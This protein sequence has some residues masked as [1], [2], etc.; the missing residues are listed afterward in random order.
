M[1]A[2]RRERAWAVGMAALVAVLLVLVGWRGFLLLDS[3]EAAGVGIGVAVLVIAAVGAWILWRSVSFGIRMQTL[4]RE[5]EAEG[6]LPADELPRRPSGRAD[7]AAA[8]ALFEQRRAEVEADPDDWR[9]WFRLALAYDDAGDR[10]RGREAA[11]A[12]ISRYRAESR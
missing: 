12:A 3:G 11:R 10:S 9:V 2:A 7:R 4:A 8:D 6:G 1:S 5:L